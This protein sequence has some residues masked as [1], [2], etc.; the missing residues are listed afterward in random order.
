[1]PRSESAM[2][3]RLEVVD[4]SPINPGFMLAVV[5]ILEGN[6]VIDSVFEVDE[7]GDRWRVADVTG[8]TSNQPEVR[9]TR[10][11]RRL[12]GLERVTGGGALELYQVLCSCDG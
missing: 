5:V 3:T 2:N 9:K 4:V 8:V 12:L 10:K 11:W 1:M 7:S 6:P